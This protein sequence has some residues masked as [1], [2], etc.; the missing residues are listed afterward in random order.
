[1][2]EQKKKK[3]VIKTCIALK[4]LNCGGMVKKGEQFT[5]SDKEYNKFKKAK[6]V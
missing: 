4:A 3:P 5:C 6:A 2:T 1:M